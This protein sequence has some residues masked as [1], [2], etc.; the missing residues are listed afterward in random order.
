MRGAGPYSASAPDA[1]A[2]SVRP[3]IGEPVVTALAIQLGEVGALSTM[4]AASALDANLQPMP[5]SIL[6]AISGP[7]LWTW[8]STRVP[9]AVT[10][11]AASAT[12]RRPT[13]FDRRPRTTSAAMTATKYATAVSD[14]SAWLSPSVRRYSSYSGIGLADAANTATSEHA[15]PAKPIHDPRRARRSSCQRVGI[16]EGIG[17]RERFRSDQAVW[18]P[19][20]TM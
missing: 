3:T 16:V 13:W 19:S 6:P 11:S 1:S 10:T 20:T 5:W 15:A 12:G 14:R 8:V 18:P 4:N 9:T 17:M 2:P 7:T